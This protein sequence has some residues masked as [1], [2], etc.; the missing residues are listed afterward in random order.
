[1]Y[2]LIN[3]HVQ[4]I[5]N[6]VRQDHVTDYDWLVQN[7]SHCANQQ[8]QTEYKNYWRLN[9]ARLSANY[10]ADYFQALQAAHANSITV[11]NLAHQLYN[12][13]THK[14][15]RQSLQ[16]SFTTKLLHMVNPNAPIYDNL[17]AAIYFFQEPS[18]KLAL[19]QRISTYVAFHTFL[20]QEYQR[21]LANNLLAASIYAFRKQFN[22]QH[23]TDEKISDSLL[24]AYVAWLRKGAVTKGTIIYR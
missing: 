10:C 8:Y 11:G 23:F 15:G 21:I 5:L 1:M 3:L 16:F 7:L 24:W 20:A 2:N 22:P 4:T 9:A 6:T 18:R 17:V 19:S 14:N 13:P 12:I